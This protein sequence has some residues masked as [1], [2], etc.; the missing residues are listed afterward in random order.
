MPFHPPHHFAKVPRAYQGKGGGDGP[1]GS[2][3][4]ESFPYL[5]STTQLRFIN[6]AGFDQL[7][8]SIDDHYFI[9]TALDAIDIQPTNSTTF[10]IISPGQ[11]VTALVCPKN[12]EV[13]SR[14]TEGDGVRICTS[15]IHL[16]FAP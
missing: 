2:K 13:K 14:R 12:S 5:I 9:I 6:S 3:Q 7:Y 1:E 4:S 8:V 11:R 10:F 15:C 16:R